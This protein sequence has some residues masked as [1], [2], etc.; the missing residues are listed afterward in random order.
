MHTPCE[1]AAVLPHL[2]PAVRVYVFQRAY[3]ALDSTLTK[4]TCIK[5][6][7]YRHTV[8]EN[9]SIFYFLKLCVGRRVIRG[10]EEISQGT[11]DAHSAPYERV[12]MPS[13]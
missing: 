13:F 8:L 6:L 3:L 10:T 4:T 9:T 11:E 12:A 5:P 2:L 1:G 7:A